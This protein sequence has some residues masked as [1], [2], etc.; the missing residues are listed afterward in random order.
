M[1]AERPFPLSLRSVRER[2]VLVDDLGV[3]P[4]LA[5]V[6]AP[7]P[8]GA[9]VMTVAELTRWTRA[10]LVAC[11][12][13]LHTRGIIGALPPWTVPLPIAE[14][15]MLRGDPD[16]RRQTAAMA[17][18]ERASIATLSKDG[19]QLTFAESAFTVH[20]AALDLD[21]SA[22]VQPL[23]GEPAPLLVVRALAEQIMPPDALTP[24]TLRELAARTG[25]TPKQVRIALRRLSGAG[26][27]RANET[28]GAPVQFAFTAV[29]RGVG[30]VALPSGEIAARGV[31]AAQQTG[32]P[33]WS[34]THGRSAG[35]ASG[36]PTDVSPPSGTPQARAA[37]GRSTSSD[38]TGPVA[39]T[40]LAV[41][42]AASAPADSAPGT[43]ARAIALR[44]TL[45]GIT[46]SLG[47]GLQ[48]HV[49]LDPDGVP[50]ISFDD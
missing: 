44:L 13:M 17:C 42:P 6:A 25:Y 20:R 9:S 7:V 46:L 28:A 10:W 30:S 16:R 26:L 3:L 33:A 32:A 23:N 15:P 12:G 1:N 43:Q 34:W 2:P 27:L 21:W 38:G 4:Q 45:N 31:S 22:I 35:R 24:V 8:L 49:A 48:P 36:A 29:A 47:P 18:L 5:A 39:P 19:T 50:R 41:A 37:A 14:L 40:P 11:Q